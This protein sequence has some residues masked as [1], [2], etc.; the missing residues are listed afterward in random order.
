MNEIDRTTLNRM[1]DH[2]NSFEERIA[3]A[4]YFATPDQLAAIK[5]ALPGVFEKY[6]P[7][8]ITTP[9]KIEATVRP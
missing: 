1:F 2:G 3:H 6:R 9:P 7:P 4:L 5:H 8:G